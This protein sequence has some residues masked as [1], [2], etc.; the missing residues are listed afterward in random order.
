MLL[1]GLKISG[2]FTYLLIGGAL[3]AIGFLIIKPVLSIIAIPLNV[4]TLGLFSF[5]TSAAVLFVITMFYPYIRVTNFRFPSITLF[6]ATIHSFQASGVLSYV[7]ISATIYFIAR[8]L[9]W[10]FE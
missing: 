9:E 7:L 2:G 1:P 3:L 10:L 5:L 4:L 6:G 8:G